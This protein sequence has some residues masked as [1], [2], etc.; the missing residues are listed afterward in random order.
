[1]CAYMEEKKVGFSFKVYLS[2]T[3]D[4]V[5]H[6]FLDQAVD[7]TNPLLHTCNIR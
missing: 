7:P 6:G 5:P 2:M 3:W 1:M 4:F